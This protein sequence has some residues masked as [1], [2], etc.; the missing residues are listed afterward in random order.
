MEGPT[1]NVGRHIAVLGL[2]ITV[3][4]A[5]NLGPYKHLINKQ[6]NRLTAVYLF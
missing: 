6:I 3:I 2:V 4:F 5:G 1:S